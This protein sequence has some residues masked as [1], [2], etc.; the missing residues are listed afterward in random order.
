[1]SMIMIMRQQSNSKL[2]K[3]LTLNDDNEDKDTVNELSIK[4]NFTLNTIET[5]DNQNK[6]LSNH[7]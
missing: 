2:Q 3:G 5:R 6:W 4:P 7:H 1:M